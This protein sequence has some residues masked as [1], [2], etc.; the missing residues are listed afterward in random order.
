MYSSIK[1]RVFEGKKF[2]LFLWVVIIAALVVHGLLWQEPEQSSEQPQQT[3][4]AK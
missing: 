1:E 3:Q 2:T 4:K